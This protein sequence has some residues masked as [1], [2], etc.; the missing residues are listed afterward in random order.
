VRTCEGCQFYARKTNLPTHALQTILVTWPFAVLGLY[1]VEPLRKAPGGY[2]HLLVSVDKFSKWIEARPITNLRTEQAVSF[3]TNITHR[4]GCRIPSS[5][6]TGP[7]L[8][9]GSSWRFVTNTTS[10]WIGRLSHIHRPMVRWSV[11][12]A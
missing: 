11:P 7:N 10:A 8:L 4:F 3:F 5:L 12:T 2:T 1:I 9:A 6:T